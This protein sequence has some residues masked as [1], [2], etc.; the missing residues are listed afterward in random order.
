MYFF[1]QKRTL[2]MGISYVRKLFALV[3]LVYGSG[4][5]AAGLLT[6][7]GSARDTLDIK[8]HNVS[9]IIENGYAIT[10]VEQIFYNAGDSDLEAVYSFPVPENAAVG[11]FTYWIDGN[12]VS[13]EVLETKQ[14]REIYREEKQAGREVALTEQD[15]FK[16]FDISIS[17]VRARQDVRIS[18]TYIKATHVDT[19]IGRYVYPLEDGGVDEQKLSFWTYDEVVQEKFSFNLT[20]RTAYPIDGL[21]LPQHPD[22]LVSQVSE[23]EWT[24]SILKEVA[25][26]SEEGSSAQANTVHTLDRDVVVYWRLAEGLPA[27]VDFVTFK[28][29]GSKRGT[30]MMTITPGDDLKRIHEGTDWIFVLDYSGS[31]QGKYNTLI[32]GVNEGL[33][34]LNPDDRFRVILFNN[35]TVELTRG[36]TYATVEN[37]ETAVLSMEAT[38]PTGGTNLYSGLKAG[39]RNLDDDRSSAI[40]LVTDG[41]ANVGRTERK[42]FLDLL[43]TKDVRLFTFVMGN[44]ANRPLLE[45]MAHVSNGFAANISNSDDIVGKLLEATTKL[46]HEAFHDVKLK[47]TGIKVKDISPKNIGSIYRGEQLIVFGHYWGQGTVDV[48]LNARVSGEQVDYSTSF[49]LSQSSEMHPELERLWAFASI[50]D[51]QNQMDYLGADADLSQAITDIAL[52]YGLVTEYTSMLVMRE[53]QFTSRGIDRKNARR[54]ARE[55][56]ARQARANAPVASNRVDRQ[57]PMYSSP[58]PTH[59]PKSGGGG[60]FGPWA[61]LILLPL[62]F[63]ELYRRKIVL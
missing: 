62:L 41:V 60:A 52:E 32:E 28:N 44:S 43:K 27:S 10:T 34:K 46:T 45:G 3:L 33:R 47:V 24:V 22:A 31:M 58:A 25:S 48:E 42:D 36:L 59:A 61:I 12:P 8:E 4:S 23:Y 15:T 63:R 38:Q 55:Q 17:P 49:E 5:Y 40:I 37:V 35:S 54:V 1:L 29:E 39:L 6:P 56:T 13:G 26:A 16:T 51:L 20:F 18:H 50:E 21:R 7:T 14:A 9:V 11:E 30:F 19:A 2:I 57:Q 53:E